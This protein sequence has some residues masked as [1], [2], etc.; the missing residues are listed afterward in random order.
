MT[1]DD[2]G[3]RISMTEER[4]AVRL[5]EEWERDGGSDIVSSTKAERSKRRKNKIK[6]KTNQGQELH[7][8][9]KAP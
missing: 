3:I 8:E 7:L 9:I 1:P 2:V 4:M 5:T 6:N